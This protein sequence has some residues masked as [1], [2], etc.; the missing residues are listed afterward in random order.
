MLSPELLPR[1]SF[2]MDHRAIVWC[3]G[4]L[5]QVR[6]TIWAL[7]HSENESARERIRSVRSILSVDTYERDLQSMI[8]KF[9]VSLHQ[10]LKY[11]QCIIPMTPF[12]SLFIGAGNLWI[13]HRLDFRISHAI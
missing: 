2:G 8:E 1:G 3:H 10:H 4:V 11:F 9:Q 5:N 12:L 13:F 6:K 7:V